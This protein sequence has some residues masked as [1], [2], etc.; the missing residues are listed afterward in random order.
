MVW[1]GLLGVIVRK[2]HFIHKMQ[3][4]KGLSSVHS[5]DLLQCGEPRS[6][7]DT[8]LQLGALL[9]WE[10][11]DVCSTIHEPAWPWHFSWFIFV[12]RGLESTANEFGIEPDIGLIFEFFLPCRISIPNSLK[13]LKVQR[14]EIVMKALTRQRGW[15]IQAR[16]LL[17]H[18]RVFPNFLL[19][20]LYVGGTS[21]SS[22]FDPLTNAAATRNHPFSSEDPLGQISDS[23]DY[24]KFLARPGVLYR[25]INM[26]LTCKYICATHEQGKKPN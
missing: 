17:N 14:P 20:I 5:P 13:V 4:M 1:F 18:V 16:P 15:Q 8:S 19:E 10:M 22:F 6:R 3:D 23:V 11:K 12:A 24:E 7:L 26:R 9:S 2:S 21:P 25:M